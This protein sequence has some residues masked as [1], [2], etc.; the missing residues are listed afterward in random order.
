MKF[1]K[2]LPIKK[3]F[4][5]SFLA[6]LALIPSGCNL[7]FVKPPA[8]EV[9]LT[10]WGLF[11]PEEVFKP[12][13]EEYQKEHPNVKI[14]YQQR[15]YSTLSQ[16]KETLLTRLREGTGP[17]IFRIH[18]TWIPQFAAELAPLPADVM[19]STEFAT[20]FYPS[21]QSALSYQER[22]YALPLMYDGLLLFYNT[23]HFED[24]G[25]DRPP[26]DWEDFRN[27]AVRLTEVDE[28]TKKITRAGAA[29][30]TANNVAH[31][32]DIL[33]LM[34][35]QSRINFPTDLTARGAR[36]ALTFYTNFATRDRVWDASL[37]YSIDAFA[38]GK[39][40]MVFAPSWRLFE[41]KSLNPGLKFA[42]AAVPQIPSLPRE[43]QTTVNW[44]SFWVEAVNQDSPYK[45]EAWEFLKFLSQ[46]ENMRQL[47]S[48]E[49]KLREFG[50]PYS[51]TDLGNVL[52]THDYLAPLIDS[53]STGTSFIIAD[54]AGNDVYVEA[55]AEAV[56]SV[57]QEKD[58]DQA[59]ETL[60]NTVERFG[61]V[62]Q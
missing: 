58:V 8:K 33:G 50:E 36:D 47:Y 38:R 51:R 35:A 17:D 19:S 28:E 15:A 2:N 5:T 61:E 54:A 60:K 20:T 48:E 21:T 42:T 3:L 4:L 14:E 1:V 57:L 44:A 34:F 13:I 37:P 24:A 9:K 29:I 18:N 43:E 6:Y 39:V 31:F 46:A 7:P 59:L 53:A 30:G 62:G 45:R 40:S 49:A 22:L 16:H 11:E 26:A 23:E 41:I 10:Y 25:I 32:S 12:L 52:L 27:I 56:N 55:M